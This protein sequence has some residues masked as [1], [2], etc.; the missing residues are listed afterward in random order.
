MP[1]RLKDKSLALFFTCGVSLEAWR[2]RGMLAREVALYNELS[3]HFREI[4]FFTYGGP[5]ETGFRDCLAE[6]IVIVPKKGV[7]N[8][9]LYSFLMPFIHRRLLKKIHFLKTNQMWGAWSAVLAKV[10]YRKKLLVRTGYVLSDDIA[11]KKRGL[12]NRLVSGLERLAYGLADGIITTSQAGFRYIAA[13]YRPRAIPVVVPNYVETDIFKPLD[14]AKTGGSLCFLGRLNPQK[15]LPALLEALRGLP[16]TLD[17][18]GSGE[19]G[20][21]LR[22]YAE[23]LDIKLKLLGNMPNHELPSLLNRYEVFALP[24]L[25]EGMPKALL[26]AMAC[27]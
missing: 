23:A 17:I 27:G 19:Q 24:S 21:D 8:D 25:W 18:I 13:R 2:E 5:E 9:L 11:V 4:Y 3:K 10:L 6:N 26:E 22:D 16:Y 1:T 15:N 12:F 14:T 20:K 7:K